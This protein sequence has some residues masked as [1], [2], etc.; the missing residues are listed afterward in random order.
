MQK[1][2]YAETLALL[3]QKEFRAFMLLRFVLMLGL[4]AQFT[5]LGYYLF[6]KT[7]DPLALGYLGL[8]EFLPAIIFSFISGYITDKNDKQ[9]IYKYCVYTYLIIA[10]IIAAV[11]YW[12]AQYTLDIKF[13]TTIIYSS[14]F[15][16]GVA[17]S[18]LAPASFSIL[19]MLASEKQYAQAITLSTTTWYLGNILGP[20]AC[21]IGIA[22]SGVGFVN[23]MVMLAMLISVFCIHKIAPK[24]AVIVNTKEPIMQ[25]LRLGFQFIFQSPLI[26]GCLC[27][28]LFA[29]LF[30][31]A[32]TLLP[33]FRQILSV[34]PIGF[35]LLRSAHGLGS[36]FLT[37]IMVALPL[38]TQ[39]GK[40]LLFSVFMY[41][42]CIILFAISKNFYWSFVLLFLGGMLDCVSVVIRQSVLQHHTPTAIKGR[43]ASINNLF[44]S[45]S[46]ELG[47]FESGVAAKW[48]GVVPSVVFGGSVTLV[49]VIITAILAPSL[50]K[51]N[52]FYRNP[53]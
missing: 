4:Y 10:I 29:V 51:M 5:C 30:G 32:E 47:G 50:R 24:P 28:D 35:G 1:E 44:I 31:G 53:N 21:G 18:F 48:M 34:G 2:K 17:R 41:G 19:P 9:K 39:V 11:I 38:K 45:S 25:S 3:Q 27:L 20:L 52:T 7:K 36:I 12:D 14:V 33:I 42:V 15:L 13:I 22:L 23:A 26:L 46:N 16:I 6:E 49:V 8:A 43:V 37:F 40:K